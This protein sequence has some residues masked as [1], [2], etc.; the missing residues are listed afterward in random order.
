MVK[1]YMVCDYK[2][3]EY[4]GDCGGRL[5][6]ENGDQIGRHHSSSIGWLRGDLKGK[7]SNASDYEI[8]DLLEQPVP[9]RF[10]K[11]RK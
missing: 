1:V 10:A 11:K 2:G 8:V 6:A 3:D 5:L 7:L 4:F 9:E